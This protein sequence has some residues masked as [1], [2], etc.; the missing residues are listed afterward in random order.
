M[1]QIGTK[2][3]RLGAR[4]AYP[5]GWIGHWCPACGII[6]AFPTGLPNRAGVVAK[7]D[8]NKTAPSFSPANDVAWGNARNPKWPYGGGRCSYQIADGIITFA[9]ESTHAL[10]GQM[11]PLPDLP[12]HLTSESH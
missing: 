7:W 10:A 2:L 5:D 6:H 8:G 3:L 11:I 9:S 12:G 1:T 4:E